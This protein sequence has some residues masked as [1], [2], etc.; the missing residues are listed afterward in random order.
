MLEQSEIGIQWRDCCSG[1]GHL[2]ATSPAVSSDSE[3]LKV[4]ALTDLLF[5]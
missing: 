2:A 1:N 5:V 4:P 3:L